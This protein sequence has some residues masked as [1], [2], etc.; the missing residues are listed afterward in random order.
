MV[1]IKVRLPRET[2][3]NI[4]SGELEKLV[5]ERYSPPLPQGRVIDLQPA[6]GESLYR[7]QEH[8]I[9]YFNNINDPRRKKPITMISAP[10]VY[11]QGQEGD[12]LLTRSLR[13]SFESWFITSTRESYEPGTL[14][15]RI[16]HDY[17]II[18]V[19]PVS[20]EVIVPVYNKVP[21]DKVLQDPQGVAYLQAK[22]DTQDGSD[23]IARTLA[24]LSKLRLNHITIWTPNQSSR[25]DYQ[26]RA[27]SFGLKRNRFRVSVSRVGDTYGQSRAVFLKPQ[28]SIRKK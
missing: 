25:A 11:K 13:D 8:W 15:A 21:L 20:R 14:N 9:Q 4:P 27:T 18:V 6:D 1:Y 22:F 16:V 24:D 26:E 23:D 7:C 10:D 12:S 3:N 17:G 28:K 5:R 2:A 19:N